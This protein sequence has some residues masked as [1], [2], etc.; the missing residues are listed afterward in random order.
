M[1]KVLLIKLVAL[2]T[3]VSSHGAARM[4][5][6]ALKSI[7]Y[8]LIVTGVQSAEDLDGQLA[9][10]GGLDLLLKDGLGEVPA[11]HRDADVGRRKPAAARIHE[12]R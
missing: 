10:G 4:F 12:P 1:L 8:D 6:D 7:P 9:R 3:T 5:A 11:A 2:P